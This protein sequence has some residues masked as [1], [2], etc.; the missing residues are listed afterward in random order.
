MGIAHCLY[1]ICIQSSKCGNTNADLGHDV[2]FKKPEA[3]G[4]VGR[5]CGGIDCVSPCRLSDRERRAPRDEIGRGSGVCFA[6]SWPQ[7]DGSRGLGRR[8]ACQQDV[9]LPNTVAS[10]AFSKAHGDATAAVARAG[11]FLAPITTAE[12]PRHWAT[13]QRTSKFHVCPTMPYQHAHTARV[14]SILLHFDAGGTCKVQKKRA[15]F[16]D[17][18]GNMSRPERHG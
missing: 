13:V 3:V 5:G 2:L 15:T 10:V 11:F 1:R 7:R 9:F 8:W 4:V 16:W 6:V 17:G 14:L 18:D 12:K